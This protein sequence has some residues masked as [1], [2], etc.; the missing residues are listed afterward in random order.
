MGV[1]FPS[2]TSLPIIQ[3]ILVRRNRYCF[4]TKLDLTMMYYSFKLDEPSKELCTITT[5][6][7]KFQYCRLAM[8]LKIAPDH[9]QSIM[10]TVLEG[11]DVKIYIDDIAIFPNSFDPHV[12]QISWVLHRL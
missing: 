5:P 1:R 7:G 2:I 6:Y 8:G 10:E 11:L 4:P 3:D 12:E 9:A